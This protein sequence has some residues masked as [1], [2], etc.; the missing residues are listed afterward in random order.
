M[1]DKANTTSS[2][3]S[4]GTQSISRLLVQYSVPAIIASVAT[5][6]YNIID[7]IFIGRG[8]GAMA[9][10]GLA[11]TFPLMNLVVAFCTLIAAGG[12]TI[13]SIFLG[14]KNYRRATDTVN[15]IMILCVINSIVFG[16]LSLIFLDQILRFFGATDETIPYA[17]EFMQVI[18]LGTPITYVFIGLNNL[19]RATGYPKKAMI[20]ALLSV[21]VNLIM[22]PIFIFVFDWGIRG[23]ALATIVAQSCAFVWVLAHF[24]SKKSFI[25]FRRGNRWFTPSIVWRI[26]AIGLSPFLMNVCACVV[27]IFIN[28]ALL[29]Y[30]GDQGN[31]SIATYGI[32]NRTLMVFIMVVFGVTQGMQPILGFNYGANK[33]DRV[34]RTL[35]TGLIAG[36]SIT[37][38]GTVI[39][40]LFPARL[41]GMFTSDPTLIEMS[42]RAFRIYFTCFTFVGAQIVITNFF[43]AVGKPKL[44]IFLSLTR[45][46]VFLVPLLIILPRFYGTDGVW[47]SLTTS[48]MIAFLFAIATLA[49]EMRRQERKL[50]KN[51]IVDT[52]PSPD[53]TSE[54]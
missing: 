40:E 28:R 8:V 5:S 16:G 22:A 26:Y 20:S 51:E 45:Q 6:L 1:S 50:K 19:M 33:W 13:S 49:F 35:K 29:D 11:I 24:L 30:G 14:Q 31:M 52:I 25:H 48:D 36:V 47:A 46:L 27:V 15:N 34:K 43:Q 21:V 38:A 37:L 12:A 3:E 2:P 39:G 44:S 7:S 32:L 18:L 9:I 4:L 54:K 17:R 41:A 53:D 23:A 10:A 42:V